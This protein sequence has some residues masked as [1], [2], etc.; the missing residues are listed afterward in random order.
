M[1]GCCF[2][3]F[4]TNSGGEEGEW[5]R[6]DPTQRPRTPGIPGRTTSGYR[7]ETACGGCSS[8]EVHLLQEGFPSLSVRAPAWPR[9]SLPWPSLL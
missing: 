9:L 5:D 6:E 8:E 1:Q 2:L 3:K 7:E 4:L